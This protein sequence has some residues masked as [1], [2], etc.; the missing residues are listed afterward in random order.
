[1]TTDIEQYQEINNIKDS[2]RKIAIDTDIPMTKSLIPNT[3][4]K[5]SF[6]KIFLISTSSLIFL[7][8]ILFVSLFIS[9]KKNPDSI[10]FYQKSLKNNQTLEVENDQLQRNFSSLFRIKNGEDECTTLIKDKVASYYCNGKRVFPEKNNLN[11]SSQENYTLTFDDYKGEKNYTEVSKEVEQI[12]SPKLRL[13]Q[14]QPKIILNYVCYPVCWYLRITV[15][16]AWGVILNIFY[17]LLCENVCYL[18]GRKLLT[19]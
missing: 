19:C 8:I 16:S 1:M 18:V 2:D 9:L 4:R 7:G 11:N 5:C 10:S 15:R 12:S 6:W 3:K 14:C 17:K 13:L